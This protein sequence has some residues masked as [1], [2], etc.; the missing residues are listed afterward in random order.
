MNNILSFTIKLFLLFYLNLFFLNYKIYSECN[1]CCCKENLND[2]IK[3][4]D[5]LKN[6]KGNDDY[7]NDDEDNNS[8]NEKNNKYYLNSGYDI[9]LP[10]NIEWANCNCSYLGLFRFF[11]S[12][13][14][15]LDKLINKKTS[16][17][18]E[19]SKKGKKTQ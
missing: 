6:N 11:L 13:K 9:D 7:N 5:D 8:E 12:D 10:L 15:F 17:F 18:D 1:N 19:F 4:D 2:N 14:Y 16:I 3:N